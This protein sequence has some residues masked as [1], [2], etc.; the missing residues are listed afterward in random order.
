MN[1]LTID[2]SPASAMEPSFKTMYTCEL[3]YVPE[4]VGAVRRRARKVLK[5]WGMPAEAVR[6]AM[7]V[8][9]DL[10]TDSITNGPLP[11]E[12]RLCLRCDG[13][14]TVVRVEVAGT[15]GAS[16]SVQPGAASR[17]DV[18]GFGSAVIKALAVR[19]GVDDHSGV[20]TRWVELPAF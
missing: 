7:L 18:F 2:G 9:S 16:A 13:V 14:R 17:H 20:I 11:A 1:C 15:E 19:Y 12:L 4:G 6:E 8:I 3:P 10:V 5:T